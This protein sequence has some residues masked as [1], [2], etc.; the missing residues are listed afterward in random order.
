[1]SIFVLPIALSSTASH[2]KPLFQ[3]VRE[4]ESRIRNK[5]KRHEST[6]ESASESEI[7]ELDVKDPRTNPLSLNPD[8]VFQYRTAGLELNETLPAVNQWPHRGFTEPM[9]LPV[10]PKKTKEASKVKN[11]ETEVCDD[12]SLNMTAKAK[13]NISASKISRESQ[14]HIRHI[15]VLTA[16]LHRCLQDGDIAR[17]SR[18]WGLL[19]RLQV[20]G[21]GIDL[22]S[23]GYWGIG[24]ELLIRGASMPTSRINTSNP[25]TKNGQEADVNEITGKFPKIPS[26]RGLAEGLGRA[27]D[28]YERLIIEYPFKRQ[29]LKSMSALNWWPIMAGCEIYKIQLEHT[30]AYEELERKDAIKAPHDDMDEDDILE[31]FSNSGDSE[32]IS[33]ES[34]QEHEWQARDRIRK[35]SL[36][37]SEN[38][39][40]RLDERMVVP[41]FSE[42]R[43]MLWLRGM[44]ALYIGD[45]SVPEEFEARELDS[46]ETAWPERE[47]SFE[48]ERNRIQRNLEL[49]ERHNLYKHGLE[50]KA[51]EW[52]VA[53]DFFEKVKIAGGD[54]PNLPDWRDYAE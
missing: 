30:I 35:I 20:S 54:P 34:K 8:E 41:P 37:A 51:R 13:E 39:A 28:F 48:T 3:S 11:T 42:S 18:A 33:L 26:H 7:E 46:S 25:K 32:E 2:S 53:G 31:D 21:Q 14:L 19:T 38:L 47:E 24:A 40:T 50:K 43:D 27:I 36:H 4:N 6:S 16:I 52:Q 17:A 5:R 9:M 23:S 29:F 49:R 10:R 45:L 12:E 15:K 1:M 22:R 44:L